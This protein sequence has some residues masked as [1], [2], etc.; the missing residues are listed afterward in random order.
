MQALY[1]DGERK[2]RSKVLSSTASSG[3]ANSFRICYKLRK[4]CLDSMPRMMEVFMNIAFIGLGN[5][6]SGMAR[7]L[8]KAGHTLAVY[9]RTRNRAE[10]VKP[11]AARAASTPGE[12]PACPDAPLTMPS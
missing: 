2:S 1:W 4:H 12:A 3:E 7:N 10:E 5:M 9:N 8:I 6:G 11:L